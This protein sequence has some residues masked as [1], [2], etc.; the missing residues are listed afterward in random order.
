MDHPVRS[1]FVHEPAPDHPGWHRWELSDPSLFNPQVM[2]AM[3]L[4]REGERRARLRLLE[5]VRRH[6]NLHD[7]VHG[8]VILALVDIAMFAGTYVLAGADVAGAVTL[9]VNCQFI[10]AGRIGEPLDAVT[11]LLRETRRLVF[12]R[13]TVEQGDV[14]VAAYSGTIRKP[15][16]PPGA[17]S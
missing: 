14:L 8:G 5:T 4:R 15:T 10:G 7:N 16:T 3:I 6:S 17:G 11:E 9:D 1:T 2:G 12:V 13:G